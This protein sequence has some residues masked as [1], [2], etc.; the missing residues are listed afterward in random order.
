MSEGGLAL[1]REGLQHFGVDAS[2]G[3][4]SAVMQHLAMVADWNQR[5]NLT[6]IT[7]ERDMV[8]KHAVDSAT[9]LSITEV[10]PG[11][12]LADIGTGAGFPGVTVKCLVPGVEVTLVESLQ[13]R[14]KFLEA[15]GAE[16]ISQLPGG[17]HGYEVV[18]ARAE[19]SGQKPQFREQF[20]VVVAR[21]VA[22]LR[23]LGEYCLPLV[24]VGGEFVAMKGPGAEAEVSAAEKALQVL[25]GRLLEARE[26]ELPH[27]VGR[28]TLVRIRKERA[29]PGAYPR[30]A[31]TPEKTPL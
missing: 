5:I 21:A 22:E 10:R 27:Q 7:E 29:T 31:G 16:V 8:L 24:R 2:E 20:D 28:R 23:I 15:V 11:M 12:K 17:Q 25:G 3:S 26:I 30:R 19:E 13:K 6:A 14:C 4:L 9:L 18:W 1:L